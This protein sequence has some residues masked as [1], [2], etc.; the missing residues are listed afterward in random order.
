MI[1]ASA[2]PKETAKDVAT[3][4]ETLFFQLTADTEE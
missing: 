2:D 1:T 3:F 4:M